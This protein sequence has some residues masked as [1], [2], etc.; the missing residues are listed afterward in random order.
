MAAVLQVQIIPVDRAAQ[1]VEQLYPH[2]HVR[3]DRHAN[4][5]VV[6]APP[7]D[8]EA[9][10]TVVQGLDVKNPTQPSLQMTQLKLAKPAAIVARLRPLFPNAQLSVATKTSVLIRATPLDMSQIQSLITSMDAPVVTPPPS[11]RP[12]EAVEVRQA[13]PKVVGRAIAHE[14]PDVRVSVSGSNL[15]LTGD[16]DQVSKAKDLA[17]SLDTP[18]YGARYTEVYHIKNVDATSVGDLITRSFASSRVTI[19]TNLNALS[20]QANAGDQ[21]RISTAI[22]QLDGAATPGQGNNG[23]GAA[24]GGSNIDVVQLHAPIPG[25]NEGPSTS[26]QDIATAVTQALGQLAPDLRVTVPANT[27]EIL[28]A[29]SPTSIRLAKALIAKIDVI[30]Q[31]VV[32]DTEILEI[33]ESAAQNLGLELPQAVLS[34]TYSEITPPYGANGQPGPIAKLQQ[35]TRTPLQL[36]AQLNLLIQKGYGRVLADPR[37]TTLSGHTASIHAGD[38]L[39]ILTTTGG[40]VGTTVT[41]QIQTFNT[42]VQLD[43]TPMVNDT[44]DVIVELHPVVNSLEGIVN[45]VPQIS[46]RDTQTTVSLHDNETLIIGGLIQEESTKETD[47]LPLLGQLPLI[48]RLFRNDSTSYT[49]NELVLV[50]TPHIAHDGVLLPPETQPVPIPSPGAL[51][52]LPPGMTLPNAPIAAVTTPQPNATPVLNTPIPNATPMPAPTPSA[53]A[54]ANVYVYGSP[55][56]NAYAGPYDAPQIFY[57]QF[58]PTVLRNGM[59]VTISAITT[60]NVT[61]VTIGTSSYTTALTQIAPSKWQ[62]TYTF[63]LIGFSPSQPTAQVTLTA[64]RADGFSN[65]IQIPVSVL[66]GP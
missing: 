58:G 52:T 20:V 38:T 3:V 14:F 44:G 43:I 56:P 25:P 5:I 45:G 40:G 4:A 29:G 1:I 36:T 65:A 15:L 6:V 49:R 12:V 24:Y 63:N 11:P 66:S 28:L 23:G 59:P 41:Q 21:Q 26:A 32:L 48:G 39:A 27:S 35:L 51:P 17:A 54:S 18:A 57:A 10:R 31:Q 46:T 60:T 42:G 34:T 33:D 19:D 13:S 8:I 61:K 2:A 47:S 16:P 50:V 37:V 53:F 22:A 30:P 55:P 7:S 9:I 64:Y 62:A